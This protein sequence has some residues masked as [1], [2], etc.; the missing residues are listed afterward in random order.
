MIQQAGERTFDFA[1][2]EIL[3]IDKPA[4]ITSFGVVHKIRKWTHCKKVGHG[5]TLDPMATG[6]LLIFTGKA[7]KQV[8]KFMDLSKIYEGTIE[9]GKTTDTD[10]VQGQIIEIKEVPQFEENQVRAVLNSFQG[11]IDQ[12]PPMFS[13]LKK[14]G[15]R[16]Y[17]L[18]RQGKVVHREPRKVVVHTI[19]LLSYEWPLLH[20]RVHCSKGTYI[21]SIA[22][23]VGSALG[24]GGCLSALRRTQIGDYRVDDAYTLDEFQQ[25]LSNHEYLLHN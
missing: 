3:N 2:G 20:I 8:P 11:E 5:G 16:L 17:K 23:D 19:D 25:I 10:D 4:G 15:K 24:T 14:D 13:A 1:A 22:R 6:V 12:V 18:A 21:R 7:T 9:L